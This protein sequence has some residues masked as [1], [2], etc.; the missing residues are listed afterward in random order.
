[1]AA[2]HAQP[3]WRRIHHAWQRAA[4]NGSSYANALARRR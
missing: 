3:R 4:F 2:G 1:V